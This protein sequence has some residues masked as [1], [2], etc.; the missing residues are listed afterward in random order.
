MFMEIVRDMLLIGLSLFCG[1][2]IGRVSGMSYMMDYFS[3]LFK[4]FSDD[5]TQNS[6]KKTEEKS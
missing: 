6:K 1:F 5:V 3:N 4:K 2:A